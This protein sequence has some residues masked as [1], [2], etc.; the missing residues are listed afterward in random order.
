MFAQSEPFQMLYSQLGRPRG[1]ALENPQ[2][3]SANPDGQRR[4]SPPNSAAISLRRPVHGAG[5]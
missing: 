1:L 4:T 3:Y 2:P 5:I